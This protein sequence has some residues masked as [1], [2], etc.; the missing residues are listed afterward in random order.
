MHRQRNLAKHLKKRSHRK[1]ICA[2]ATAVFKAD[3]H[4]Q[5][6]E[7]LRL[8]QNR[9]HPKEPRAVRIFLKDIDLSLTFYNQPKD[10]WKQLVS[11]NLIERQ[12]REFI[13]SDISI[14]VLLLMSASLD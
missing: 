2:D 1:A 12:M 10:K 13:G 4:R 5:A 8:F 9:W 11:N 7:L 14:W 3:N 6:I